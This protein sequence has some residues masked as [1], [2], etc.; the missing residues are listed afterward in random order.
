FY[1]LGQ[2]YNITVINPDPNV[3]KNYSFFRKPITYHQLTLEGFINAQGSGQSS[4]LGQDKSNS[5]SLNR[6]QL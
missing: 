5:T 6:F 3:I 4:Y 1:N 2:K